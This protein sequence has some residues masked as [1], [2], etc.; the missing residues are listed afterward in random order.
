MSSRLPHPDGVKNK[1]EDGV[2]TDI[3]LAGL[4]PSL[5]RPIPKTA[6][7]IGCANKSFVYLVSI[8]GTAKCVRVPAAI[9]EI[10]GR[11]EMLFI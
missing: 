11:E 9:A 10:L 3:E 1:P 4:N 2:F 6:T 8:S 5:F 7:Q